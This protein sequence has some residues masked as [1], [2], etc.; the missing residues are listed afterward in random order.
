M[1]TVRMMQ[2]GSTLTDRPDGKKAFRVISTENTFPVMLDFAGVVSFG[3][4]FGDEVILKV[5]ELQDNKIT[6]LNT[7]NVI[8]NSILRIVEDKTIAIQFC[9]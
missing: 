7:N 5:A 2:F 9:D 1:S 8:R 3:S 4:S 6:V